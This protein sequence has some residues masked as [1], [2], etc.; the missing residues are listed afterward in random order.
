[1]IDDGKRNVTTAMMMSSTRTHVQ[2]Q[3]EIYQ[4]AVSDFECACFEWVCL[5]LFEYVAMAF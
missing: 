5:E 4:V 2:E 1:M 3:R